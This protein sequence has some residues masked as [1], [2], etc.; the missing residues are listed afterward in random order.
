MHEK[1]T[2]VDCGI[3]P[4]MTTELLTEHIKHYAG[5][6]IEQFFV[7][8]FFLFHSFWPILFFIFLLR[9]MNGNERV[10]ESMVMGFWFF[11]L[12]LALS[13]HEGTKGCDCRV[14]C[15]ANVETEKNG[16]IWK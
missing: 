1:E 8:I 12:L 7:G 3:W 5:Q 14:K 6:Y 11:F 16:Q 2:L 9:E 15:E 10:F 4:K 13:W